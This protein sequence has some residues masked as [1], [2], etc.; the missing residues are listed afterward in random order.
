MDAIREE[1]NAKVDSVICVD[2]D[3]QENKV[4]FN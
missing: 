1:M 4:G 3:T 2:D